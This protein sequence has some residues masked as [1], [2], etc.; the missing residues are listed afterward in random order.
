MLRTLCMI[1]AACARMTIHLPLEI[2][3]AI[4][5]ELD[6]VQDLRNVRMT[7]HAL[8][9]AVT[10]IAFRTLSVTSTKRSAQNLGRLLDLPDIAAHV[11]KFTYN[12]TGAITR[13]GRVLNHGAF[14]PP[15]P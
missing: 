4:F 8:C 5:K 3:I 15:I 6:D 13:R 10:P 9:T 14:S 11:R 2:L 1:T 12:D 7:C